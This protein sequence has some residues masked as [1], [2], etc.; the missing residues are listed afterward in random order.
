M[1][2]TKII[3]VGDV[4]VNRSNPDSIF[5]L[6]RSQ[7]KTKQ[8]DIAFCQIETPYS[9]RGCVNPSGSFTQIR[10][11]PS[12]VT[13]VANAG[14]NV[15]SF[16]TNH[17]LDY[18]FEAFDD[19]IEHCNSAGIRVF[20]AGSNLAEARKPLIV[21]SNGN[22]I[23][24]LAYCSILP[25]RFAAETR[26]A[27]CAPARA[28]AVYEPIEFGQPGGPA[29]VVT[30]PHHEDS[31]AMLSD[32]RHLK[33]CVDIVIVSMHW[34]IH[35][36]EGEI[37]MYERVYGHSAIDAGADIILGHHQ[38]ILKPIEIY[39]GKPIFY[40][41]NMFAFDHWYPGDDWIAPE[42]VLRR[43][44]L[45]P[46]WTL[47]PK[48]KTF[49]F[50]VDSRKSI[51]VNI[52]CENKKV[53]RVSWNPL[54]INENSQPRYLRQSEPEFNEVVNYIKRITEGQHFSTDFMSSGDEIV[55]VQ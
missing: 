40:G 7:T 18:G 24:W 42:R 26:R 2:K 32:I 25:Y 4:V 30:F 14:F 6:V 37:A 35:F 29:R 44:S 54:M 55:M 39:R 1:G 47:D 49:P 52:D 51:L 20:G 5:D 13:A 38:H 23:G 43:A 10:S 41:L 19:T 16:A 17:C 33:E 46:T 31:E 8:A 50:P 36:K 34:G 3:A 48:Y 45:N 9:T 15:G 27:G 21:E 11:D 12:N 53:K 28:Y 22:K